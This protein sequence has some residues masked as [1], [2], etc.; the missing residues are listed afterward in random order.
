M[1]WLKTDRKGD[2]VEKIIYAITKSM[3]EI[4]PLAENNRYGAFIVVV[5][6]V[7]LCWV[8]KS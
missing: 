3:S 5:G 4:I 2:E 8:I 7:A 1:S 6:V